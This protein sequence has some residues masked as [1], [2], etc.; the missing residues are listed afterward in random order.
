MSI[1]EIKGVTDVQ[2]DA[3]KAI[4]AAAVFA[5]KHLELPG[6]LFVTVIGADTLHSG[7]E[8]DDCG[9]ALYHSGIQHIA[10]AG[11]D[12]PDELKDD[13]EHWLH[14]LKVSTIHEV[15]HYWQELQGT[16]TGSDENED[17]AEKMAYEIA[18]LIKD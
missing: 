18:A 7:P 3:W 5:M 2:C 15:V 14:E 17:E 10:V 11:G 9:F 6:Y 12:G 1:R 16:L 13:R 4:R 8:P